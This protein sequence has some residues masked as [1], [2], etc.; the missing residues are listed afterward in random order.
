M[1]ELRSAGVDKFSMSL[2]AHDETTYNIICRPRFY[3]PFHTIL[4]FIE[5]AKQTGDTEPTI[6]AVPEVNIPQVKKFAGQLGIPLR[7]QEYYTS[8]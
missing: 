4:D 1:N 7:I 2:N 8:I 5:K 6:V 3:D